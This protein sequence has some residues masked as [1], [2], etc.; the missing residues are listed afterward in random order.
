MRSS[1][2]S[3]TCASGSRRELLRIDS[4]ATVAELVVG[5]LAAGGADQVEALGQ[6]ALVGEVVERGQQLALGEVARR[7][8]DDHRR[9]R[10]RQPLEALDERV[11]ADLLA[12]RVGGDGGRHLEARPG[13]ALDLVAAELVAQ[14][15][16]HL[17]RV[18]ALVRASRSARRGRR[19]SPGSGPRGPSRRPASSGPRRSPRRSRPGPRG[20]CPP[21]RTPARP[22]RSSHERTTEPRFQS[23]AT[24]LS[25]I[26]NFDLCIISKPSA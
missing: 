2:P 26:G 20:R 6:R 12:R 11:L 3:S 10:D 23:P 22:A 13:G 24:S 14:R 7:A 16:Q 19:R 5:L 21:A 8:E 18:L 15:G 25:S 9:R 1:S 17:V 4:C